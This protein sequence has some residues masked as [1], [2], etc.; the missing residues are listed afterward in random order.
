M[1][2]CEN[3]ND[4]HI[5]EVMMNQID[6]TRE[7]HMK[8]DLIYSV[9]ATNHI[10]VSPVMGSSGLVK[11]KQ[12]PP[13]TSHIHTPHTHMY[14]NP[15]PCQVCLVLLE[16]SSLNDCSPSHSLLR[17]GPSPSVRLLLF[18]MQAIKTHPHRHTHGS[19]LFKSINQY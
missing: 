1:L 4:F 5:L 15:S 14:W 6:E 2:L 10:I 13:P 19:L 16:Q 3:T 11:L 9:C 12:P 18:L 17:T 7:Q 8:F